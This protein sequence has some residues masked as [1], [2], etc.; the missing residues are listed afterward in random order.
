[1]YSNG[2]AEEMTLGEVA[3]IINSESN[4][5]KVDQSSFRNSQPIS[6]PVS[7][8]R[9]NGKT[10]KNVFQ[11]LLDHNIIVCC[12]EPVESRTEG[13]QTKLW[14]NTFDTEEQEVTMTKTV[15]TME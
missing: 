11:A 2:M 12:V 10:T 8:L 14:F 5:D 3:E 4:T 6:S 9:I 1:M 7:N 15:H 13:V